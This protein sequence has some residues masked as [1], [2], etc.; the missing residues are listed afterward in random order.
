MLTSIRAG[1]AGYGDDLRYVSFYGL[2]ISKTQMFRETLSQI[3]C[4]LCGLRLPAESIEIV[5]LGN[6]GFLSFA[7][8]I[9]AAAGRRLKEVEDVVGFLR[10]SNFLG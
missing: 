9:A 10:R 4:Y 6:D 5:R 7:L 1:T 3:D 2:N 8:P